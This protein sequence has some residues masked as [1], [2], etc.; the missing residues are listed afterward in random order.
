MKIYKII[1]S[2]HYLLFNSHKNCCHLVMLNLIIEE[3]YF[4]YKILR[5]ALTC[6]CWGLS[7]LL[8]IH[9]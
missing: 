2:V 9:Q 7:I 4:N 3:I 8:M 5:I 6:E 1:H